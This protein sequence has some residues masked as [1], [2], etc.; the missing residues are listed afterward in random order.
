MDESVATRPCRDCGEPVKIPPVVPGKRKQYPTR[1]TKCFWLKYGDHQKAARR[2]DSAKERRREWNRSRERGESVKAREIRHAEAYRSNYPEKQRAKQVL[3]LAIK[4]GEIQRPTACPSCGDESRGRD[5]RALI[6]AHH[7]DYSKP[8]DVQWLCVN[9]H[10]AIHAQ[11]GDSS[12][13]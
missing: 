8:L 1:C 10:A 11:Q 9:C 4:R 3:A 7:H 5:G 12:H 6:Q 13:A 2:A